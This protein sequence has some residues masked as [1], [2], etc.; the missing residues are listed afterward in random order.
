MSTVLDIAARP[1]FTGRAFGI[2]LEADFPIPG[3]LDGATPP[4][5][6][7]TGKRR[8][9][10]ALTDTATLDGAWPLQAAQRTFELRRS[11]GR[12]IL[13]I[14]REPDAGYRVWIPGLG[15]C[16]ISPQGK[17]ILCAPPRGRNRWRLLIGQGLPIAAALQGLEVLHA[18]AVVLGGRALA[19][20]AESGTGKTSVALHLLSHGAQF[21][22]DDVVA[23]EAEG[24]ALVAHPGIGIA[25]VPGGEQLALRNAGVRLRRPLDP[26]TKHHVALALHDRAA[27]LAAA[28][29][30]E[31]TSGLDAVEI[32]PLDPPDARLL[33]GATFVAHVPTAARLIMQLDICSRIART[34]PVF[35]VRSPREWGA[36]QVADRIAH[37][38]GCGS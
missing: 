37:H 18:S 7:A 24:E 21:L 15:R 22:A 26:T 16:V 10:I 30:L 3:L 32:V 1:C 14:D 11:D 28:Y 31:R 2:K 13:T 33:L 5:R 17:G 20:I 25:H 29:F 23:L 8:I 34:V 36:A 9:H 27:P 4:L 19:F 12:S 6:R 35:R 38:A